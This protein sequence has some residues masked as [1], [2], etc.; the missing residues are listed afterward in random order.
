MPMRTLLSLTVLVAILQTLGCAATTQSG[1][2][3]AGTHNLSSRHS[4]DRAR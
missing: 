1:A 3:S 4:S 2:A